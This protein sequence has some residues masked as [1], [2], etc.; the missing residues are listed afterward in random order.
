MRFLRSASWSLSTWKASRL[1]HLRAGALGKCDMVAPGRAANI[2]EFVALAP[3][4]IV[5]VR[6]QF[7]DDNSFTRA[8]NEFFRAED[9][10][11][12][13][14][15]VELAIKLNPD[16]IVKRTRHAGQIQQPPV[17]ALQFHLQLSFHFFQ[18]ERAAHG[19][20]AQRE[21]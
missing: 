14:K 19:Q 3:N 20:F 11:V 16:R 4:G 13:G 21:V 12:E 2:P 5:K 15:L 1:A 17:N 10:V 6:E 18:V 8:G 9:V 7:L